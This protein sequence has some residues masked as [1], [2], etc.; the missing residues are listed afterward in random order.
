LLAVVIGLLIS[1]WSWVDAQVRAVVVISS[2]L[3]ASKPLAEI[4]ASRK[5]VS[6]GTPRSS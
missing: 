1:Y 3:D 5:R 6:L 2:V 4:H